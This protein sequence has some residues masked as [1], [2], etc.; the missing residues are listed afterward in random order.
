MKLFALVI[1]LVLVA[2]ALAVWALLGMYPGKIARQRNHPQADAIA[3]C[4]WWGAITLGILTPLAFIWA[5]SNPS[6]TL[7]GRLVED[8]GSEPVG[9]SDQEGR[10]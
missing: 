5:Y 1:L 7:T 4:G 8:A 2:S 9:S 10:S 6:A 3:V